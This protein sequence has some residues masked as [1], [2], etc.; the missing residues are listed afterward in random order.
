MEPDTVPDSSSSSSIRIGSTLPH[1]SDFDPFPKPRLYPEHWDLSELLEKA[2]PVA[3]PP[4]LFS[5]YEAFPKPSTIPGG[6]NLA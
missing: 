1:C 3:A 4:A 5:G 6:W 2:P